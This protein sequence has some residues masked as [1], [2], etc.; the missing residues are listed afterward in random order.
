MKNIPELFASMVLDSKTLKSRLPGD[1]YR[2]FMKTA[3]ENSP[4]SLETGNHVANAMKE[5]AIEKGAT[6]YTHWFQ[7]MQT[8]AMPFV[9]VTY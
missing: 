1:V 9:P 6:H 4:L 8:I 5:W 7:P 2:T 3:E